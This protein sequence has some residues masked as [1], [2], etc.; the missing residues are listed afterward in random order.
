MG[1]LLQVRAQ[2]DTVEGPNK[3]E[4]SVCKERLLRREEGK[5]LGHQQQGIATGERPGYDRLW[6]N[7]ELGGSVVLDRW[8]LWYGHM[9]GQ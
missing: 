5:V 3:P 8:A 2:A 9:G 6:L 7:L 4:V 1:L